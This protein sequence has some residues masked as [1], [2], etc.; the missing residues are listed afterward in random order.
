MMIS[1]WLSALFWISIFFLEIPRSFSSDRFPK[2]GESWPWINPKWIRLLFS[3]S[4]KSLFARSL[5]YIWLRNRDVISFEIWSDK[6]RYR[7]YFRRRKLFG[8]VLKS[9]TDLERYLNRNL[10]WSYQN[11]ASCWNRVDVN[12]VFLII[13]R[14]MYTSLSRK[15]TKKWRDMMFILLMCSLPIESCSCC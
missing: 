15:E 1:L 4:K 6:R 12:N 10:F 11:L 14:P 3:L 8:F 9:I 5:L 2:K 7:G 13:L